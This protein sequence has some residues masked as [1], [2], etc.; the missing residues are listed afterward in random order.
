MKIAGIDVP[1]PSSLSARRASVQKKLDVKSEG[2]TATTTLLTIDLSLQKLDSVH[3][4]FW[5][6]FKYFFQHFVKDKFTCPLMIVWAASLAFVVICFIME[7][8]NALN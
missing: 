3:V 4:R 5:N 1:A 8:K 6:Y 2:Q 7:D